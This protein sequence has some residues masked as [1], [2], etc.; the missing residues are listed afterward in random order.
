MCRGRSAPSRRPARNLLRDVAAVIAA[1]EFYQADGLVGPVS[2]LGQRGAKGRDVE[3]AAAVADDPGFASR[4][5]AEGGPGVEDL[6]VGN[7]FGGSSIAYLTNVN[8]VLYFSAYTPTYGTE[9][10]MS[11][12]T[13]S[14]TTIVQDIYPGR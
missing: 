14:G 4:L 10:W 3:H 13:A 1:G 11:D 7:A 2:R 5:G 9:L 12:G 8:G 6:D